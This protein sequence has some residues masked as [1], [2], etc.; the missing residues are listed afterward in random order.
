MSK[1]SIWHSLL[2]AIAVLAMAAGVVF[3]QGGL[4]IRE[5]FDDS[6]FPGWEVNASATMGN[7]QLLLGSNGTAVL[8]GIWEDFE[9]TLQL[10][11]NPQSN[12]SI[13]W[14]RGNNSLYELRVL[15]REMVLERLENG[16]TEQFGFGA[17]SGTGSEYQLRVVF[18]RGVVMIWVNGVNLI[19]AYDPLPLD[20]G[21]IMI[22]VNGPGALAVDEVVVIPLIEDPIY[23]LAEDEA[24]LLVPTEPRVNVR[25]GPSTEF[26][27][28]EGLYTAA[29]D[30]V[31]VIGRSESNTW[32][33]VRTENAGFGWVAMSVSRFVKPSACR[34]LPVV[35]V[36]L[37]TPP[38]PPPPSPLPPPPLP[39]APVMNWEILFVQGSAPA[40]LIHQGQCV[41]LRWNVEGV[42]AVY[43]QGGGVEGNDS[44]L[45]C[46]LTTTVYTL[47]ILNYNTTTEVRQ[48]VVNVV[49]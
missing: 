42:S 14:A 25:S 7:G 21:Q 49:Q 26:G 46:P 44:R 39:P 11:A 16:I 40:I 29:G 13:Q 22:R 30:E 24:C 37:P 18:F 4:T 33:Q 41:T 36:V 23:R 31:E 19:P 35:Q 17:F 32:V 47:T 15:A 45:V 34:N 43:F 38:P 48:I 1:W 8:P 10:E 2:V 9:L 6:V 28:V 12:F 5:S 3:G 20:S 27:I